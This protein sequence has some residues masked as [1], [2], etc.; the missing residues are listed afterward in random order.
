GGI[1]V[2]PNGDEPSTDLNVP[3]LRYA[4]ILLIKA[5]AQIMQG[6]N[7]DAALNQVRVRA[8]LSPITNA[9]MANLKHERRVELAGEWS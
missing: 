9:T 7:G 6:K 1:H 2:S 8:G 5:E 3:L 4:E